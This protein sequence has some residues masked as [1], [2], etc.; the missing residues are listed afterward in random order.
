MGIGRWAGFEVGEF[1]SH[2]FAED[3]G[4]RLSQPA[5]TRRFC[6]FEQA[7]WQCR[8]CCGDHAVHVEDV[9]YTEKITGQWGILR[10]P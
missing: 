1:G 5:H 8:A 10:Q 6:T 4:S 9:L 3:D 2:R 7:R